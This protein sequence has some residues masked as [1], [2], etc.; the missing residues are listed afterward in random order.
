MPTPAYLSITGTTQGLITEGASAA[1]S[2][3]GT[4]LSD[5]NDQS[6]I[7]AFTHEIIVPYN[8]H[9]GDNTGPHINKA[10]C[11]TK[12]FDKASPLL[13][14]ALAKGELL[15][16][17][18]IEWYRTAGTGKQERY[19][20]TTLTDAKIVGIKDYMPNCQDPAN[21]HFTHLQDVHFSYAKIVW[22]HTEANTT[23][24]YNWSA[25]EQD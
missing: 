19:Y 15:Q 1:D 7:L 20:T 23:G 4:G 6:M 11:I 24:S 18:K 13:S 12:V 14:N 3:G 8:P 17:V 2:I 16:E 9:S 10:V 21:A 5:H 25:Q 22:S